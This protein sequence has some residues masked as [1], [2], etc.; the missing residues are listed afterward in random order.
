MADSALIKALL[1]EDYQ[2]SPKESV[3]G[4]LG[5][6]VSQSLPALVN[7]YGSTGKNLATVLG[8][9]LLAGLFGYQA[10]KEA[11]QKNLAQAGYMQELLSGGITPERE[12]EILAADPKLA[13]LTTGIKLQELLG[14]AA[15]K[16]EG[17]AARQK[18]EIDIISDYAK[19]NNLSFTQAKERL[20]QGY[21]AGPSVPPITGPGVDDTYQTKFK[22]LVQEGIDLGMTANGANKYAEAILKPIEDQTK[23][24]Q[25]KANT[26]REKNAAAQKMIAT[27]KDAVE[28]A[29][30]TGGPFYVRAIREAASQAYASL[31]I[32]AGPERERQKQAKQALL[33]TIE[34]EA[35]QAL[36]SPGAVSDRETKMIVRAVP[37]K[38]FTP[39]QNLEIINQMSKVTALNEEYAN[40]L[41]EYALSGKGD[42]IEKLWSDYKKQEVFRNDKYNDDRISFASWLASKKGEEAA[43]KTMTVKQTGDDVSSMSDEDLDAAVAAI[44]LKRGGR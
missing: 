37:N 8:G 3:T 6:G 34:P 24:I 38:D 19:K 25:Q 40:A 30:E 9:S 42:Q 14:G 35:V 2:Y 31:P 10:K 18:A 29:G 20:D 17:E 23:A 4:S 43:T 16:A 41:D 36:R 28:G 1:G 22:A 12:K 33:G 39:A 11:E 32:G 26:I 21:G 5:Y 13:K 7:P 15:A 27:A 44:R